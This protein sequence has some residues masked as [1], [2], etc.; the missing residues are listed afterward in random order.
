MLYR[1]T[2]R[3]ESSGRPDQTCLTDEPADKGSL[4][5]G[6]HGRAIVLKC[7]P[8]REVTARPASGTLT[9]LGTYW[10]FSK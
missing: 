6:Q 10:G 1:L 4:F 5:Y 3:Y 7:S 9:R 8:I 2:L